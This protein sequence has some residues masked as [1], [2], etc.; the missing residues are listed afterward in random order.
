[1]LAVVPDYYVRDPVSRDFAALIEWV[2][3]DAAHPEHH[4]HPAG[5]AGFE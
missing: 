5:R 2:N 4:G 3:P 1:M